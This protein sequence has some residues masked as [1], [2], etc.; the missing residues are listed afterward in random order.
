M[1]SKRRKLDIEAPLADDPNEPSDRS[2]S[3]GSGSSL[4]MSDSDAEGGT[5]ATPG[6]TSGTGEVASAAAGGSRTIAAML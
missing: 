3:A 2:I 5:G 4:L 1:P 6:G